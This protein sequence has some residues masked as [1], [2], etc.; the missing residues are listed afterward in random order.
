MQKW[1]YCFEEGEH[2]LEDESRPDCLR[3]TEY[4][5]AIRALLA[6]DPYLSQK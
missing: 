5:D 6:N 2:S 3:S 4:I 1:M